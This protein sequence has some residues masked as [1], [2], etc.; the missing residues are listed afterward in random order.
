[1]DKEFLEQKMKVIVAKAK[2]KEEQFQITNLVEVITNSLVNMLT[3]NDLID[4]CVTFLKY[5]KMS[6]KCDKEVEQMLLDK[7]NEFLKEQRGE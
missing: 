2:I 4:D 7:V 1:M 6:G 5:Q 3:P